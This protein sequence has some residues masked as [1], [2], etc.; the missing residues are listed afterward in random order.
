MDIL[1]SV[2]EGDTAALAV[3]KYKTTFLCGIG[4]GS[5]PV[6]H[7]SCASCTGSQCS[8]CNDG[9]A[10]KSADGE[11]CYCSGAFGSNTTPYHASCAICHRNCQTCELAGSAASCY[12]CI[13]GP[14]PTSKAGGQCD[15]NPCHS[16]CR[17]CSNV[18]LSGCTSCAVDGAQVSARGT[19]GCGEGKV[20]QD[21]AITTCV[22][23]YSGC[24][25][26]TDGSLHVFQERRCFRCQRC[27]FIQ[28]ASP[29]SDQ[30]PLSLQ[31]SC[32]FSELRPVHS[33]HW[34]CYH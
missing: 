4:S 2:N 32:A 19:C 27:L 7:P 26:C 15:P 6:C 10:T 13:A 9:H 5:C 11:Y 8:S 24:A 21:P 17:T 16:S 12:T 23:C 3:A 30:P 33:G 31:H 34:S 20:Y 25:Q 14:A 18:T 29:S 1:I 28:L 22:D